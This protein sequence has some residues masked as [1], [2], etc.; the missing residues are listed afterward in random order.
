MRIFLAAA[1]A[2]A[3]FGLS[4]RAEACSCVHPPIPFDNASAV[5]LNARLTVLQPLD[6]V[7]PELLAPNGDVVA[8]DLESTTA[9]SFTLLPK[10]PLLPG[11]NYS[12]RFGRGAAFATG[13]SLDT[14]APAA[15]SLGT[16]TLSPRT[17]FPSPGTC[18]LGGEDV[19]VDFVN[20]ATEPVLFEI[21]TG[22]TTASIDLTRP[23]LIIDPSHLTSFRFGD[24]GLCNPRFAISSTASLAIQVRAVDFAGNVSELSN[25]LQLKTGGCSATGG[26]ALILLSALFLRRRRP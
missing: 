1:V 10:Q 5:P 21:F 19:T 22:P 20:H 12:V 24:Q 3:V 25:P 8:C 14:T 26:T 9:T 11:A 13:T 2:A 15:P 4:N 16:A 18:D 6:G 17:A 7:T 23:G